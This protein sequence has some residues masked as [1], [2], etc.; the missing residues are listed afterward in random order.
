MAEQD[1]V[2][3]WIRF[4]TEDGAVYPFA[5]DPASYVKRD[6]VDF[7]PRSGGGDVAYSNLDLYQIMT[8]DSW[9]HGFGFVQF[10][11]KFGY[12]ITSDGVD[13]RHVGMAMMFQAYA[14]DYSS[15]SGGLLG[16]VDFGGNTYLNMGA[17]GVWKRT[18]AGSY[19]KVLTATVND[20][21]TNGAY[22][23]ASV[24]GGR[25]KTSSDGTSWTDAGVTG[26][27]P[28]SFGYLDIHNGF[29]WGSETATT[30]RTLSGL[31]NNGASV[32][33]GQM[34]AING[35][36]S[37]AFRS[38]LVV[39]D[40]VKIGTTVIGRVTEIY[41]DT[42]MMTYITVGGNFSVGN[43]IVKLTNGTLYDCV[44]FWSSSDSS[45][46]EGG[47]VADIGAVVVG[48]GSATIK[49]ITSFNG[50]LH[51]ARQDGVWAIDDTVTPVVARRV[52]SFSDE[53]HSS[54]FNIFIPWHGRLYF[55]IKNVL[56]AYNGASLA[57]A[58][59]P[60][61]SLDYPP[62]SFGNFIGATYRGG[63]LY[64][65][66]S[67]ETNIG[68]GGTTTTYYLLA[69]DGTGWF[70]LDT[71]GTTAPTGIGYSPLVNMLFIG[72]TGGAVWRIPMQARSELPYAS[73]D[74][75]EN[76]QET[77]FPFSN[78]G[79]K[80]YITLTGPIIP[81]RVA[82]TA[83]PGGRTYRDNGTGQI[84][85]N[86]TTTEYGRM[87]YLT[88]LI[89]MDFE[90]SSISDGQYDRIT[91]NDPHY[92][93]LSEI[94]FGFRRVTKSFAEIDVEVYNVSSGSRFVFVEYSA[95]GGT[96]GGLG[97]VI[98]NG[99]TKLNITPTIE[100]NKLDVRLDF[101]TDNTAQSPILR[102]VTVKA[103]I[104]PDTLYGHQLMVIGANEVR[105]L[106]NRFNPGSSEQQKQWIEAL[107]SSKAPITFVD[108][109]GV[110]HIG[111]IS[112]AQFVDIQRRPG[113]SQSSW[114][115]RINVVEVR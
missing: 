90:I 33:S 66:A 1:V 106:D 113:E 22:L 96:W 34:T 83:E 86:N 67:T 45:D 35:N 13:T 30:T 94:D 105:M 74:V 49:A 7:A 19:S 110:S 98:T 85:E 100:A 109:F 99:V 56:Y 37:T 39:G 71:I 18:Q 70:V 62:L 93:N 44:H 88:G 77:S 87:D 21:M 101:R 64:V 16:I 54:N 5:I 57:N 46:A 52:L 8:Q 104:R 89:V 43:S 40:L 4:E 36:S 68:S 82:F 69:F 76:T 75:F 24:S 114:G 115:C 63:F 29:M 20:L 48:P 60:T 65:L 55:N 12:R 102:N 91:T 97:G 23:I 25:M 72:I 50:F 28:N 6:I 92:L 95:D 58:T 80:G 17:N 2:Y 81:G 73:F 27:P 78:S 47:G 53:Q 11:D 42:L 61:F 51:V 79:G 10:R 31:A 103:M 111:Y 108:P 107:R 84:V 112:T 32:S 41:S 9:H 59:P 3:S 14:V 15:G 38:E 26:N